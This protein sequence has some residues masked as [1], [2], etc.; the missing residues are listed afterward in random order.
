MFSLQGG[1]GR[2][3]CRM[4]SVSVCLCRS[5]YHGVTLHGVIPMDGLALP[6]ARDG[7]L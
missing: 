1:F 6:L 7:A 3:S 2:S 4:R 5:V